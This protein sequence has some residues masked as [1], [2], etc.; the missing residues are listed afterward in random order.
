ME[1]SL[2][3]KH[4]TQY[5]YYT[6]QLDC[7]LQEFLVKDCIKSISELDIDQLKNQIKHNNIKQRR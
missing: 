2:N 6:E 4:K 5:E 3:H 7:K 1:L